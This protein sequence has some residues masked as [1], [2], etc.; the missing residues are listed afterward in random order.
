[1][2]TPE[3]W[4]MPPAQD[5]A[6]IRPAILTASDMYSPLD[7]KDQIRTGVSDVSA[8]IPQLVPAKHTSDVCHMPHASRTHKKVQRPTTQCKTGI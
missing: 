8:V 1:M 4:H 5:V 2:L 7:L 3:N 6:T